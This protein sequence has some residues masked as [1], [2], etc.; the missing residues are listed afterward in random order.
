MVYLYENRGDKRMILEHCEFIEKL[1]NERS[2]A[3]HSY[4]LSVLN[5]EYLAEE[6]VQEAFLVALKKVD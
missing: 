6:A 5:D 1:Y 2:G 3:M 4:A